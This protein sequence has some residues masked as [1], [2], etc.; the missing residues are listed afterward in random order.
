MEIEDM[1]TVKVSI[2]KDG[3]LKKVGGKRTGST[4][5]DLYRSHNSSWAKEKHFFFFLEDK[6]FTYENQQD[7]R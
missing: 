1:E 4:K 7:Y 5:E 2:T 3:G 6:R